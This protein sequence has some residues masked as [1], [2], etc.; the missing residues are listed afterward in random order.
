[1]INQDF[2]I[3]YKIWLQSIYTFSQVQL[4]IWGKKSSSQTYI[5]TKHWGKKIQKIISLG[6]MSFK[7]FF[8]I[9]HL[10]FDFTFIC[11]VQFWLCKF[12]FFFG[13]R[14]LRYCPAGFQW[15]NHS[16]LQSSFLGSSDPLT[17]PSE[18]LGLQV[19]A[20]VPR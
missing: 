14:V 18:Q 11:F 20:P 3:C 13:D 10:S 9:C 6:D 2:T 16:L 12:F 7:H 4:P 5:R 19:C 8:Q 15:Y 17:L 1:M